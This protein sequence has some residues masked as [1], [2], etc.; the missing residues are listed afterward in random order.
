MEVLSDKSFFKVQK[1]PLL[2]NQPSHWVRTAKLDLEYSRI[3]TCSGLVVPTTSAAPT[4]YL[5]CP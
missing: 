5:K 2:Y 1:I 4:P 3:W